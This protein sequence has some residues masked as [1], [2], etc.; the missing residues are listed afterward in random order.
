[1]RLVLVGKGIKNQTL[2]QL[3]GGCVCEYNL[4]AGQIGKKVYENA[5]VFTISSSGIYLMERIGQVH[6][7][8]LWDIY[9]KIVIKGEK[10]NRG[11]AKYVKKH[12][13][14]VKQKT[15]YIEIEK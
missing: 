1:M 14:A 5:S 2:P 7:Y 6:K 10:V 11:M 3:P 13:V 12:S 4:F 8:I 9:Y 15:N